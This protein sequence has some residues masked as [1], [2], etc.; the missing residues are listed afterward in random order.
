MSDRGPLT[1]FSI[2]LACG[3]LVIVASVVTHDV[4]GIVCG[5]VISGTSTAQIVALRRRR[6][7][8]GISH[9]HRPR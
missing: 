3:L 8:R 9:P 6:T 2:T 1:L 7:A 4:L 5:L